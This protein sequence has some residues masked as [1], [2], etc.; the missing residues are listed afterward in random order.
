M[1]V[2]IERDQKLKCKCEKNTNLLIFW[3]KFAYFISLNIIFYTLKFGGLTGKSL[4]TF[5]L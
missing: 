1:V 2:D 4:N 5:F 3:L